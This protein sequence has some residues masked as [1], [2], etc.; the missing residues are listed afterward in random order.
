[1]PAFAGMTGRQWLGVSMQARQNNLQRCKV[2]TAFTKRTPAIAHS[3]CVVDARRRTC[4]KETIQ[5]RNKVVYAQ[6][7]EACGGVFYAKAPRIPRLSTAIDLKMM[8]K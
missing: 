1:M 6:V 8:L 5:R 4:R 3:D 2:L 7:R